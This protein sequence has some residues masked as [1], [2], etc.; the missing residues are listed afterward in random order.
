M[1]KFLRPGTLDIDSESSTAADEWDMWSSNFDAFFAAIDPALT[2]NKL[3]LLRAHV[4]CHIFKLIKH[5]SSYDEAVKILKARFIKPKSEVYARHCLAT[6]KQQAGE[7]LDQFLD[8]LK[9]L[10][11]DCGFQA[12]SA[13]KVE[14]LAIRDAFITGMSSNAIRQRL[15]ENLELDLNT[16]VKQ[17]RALEMAQRHSEAYRSDSSLAAAPEATAA[18]KPGDKSNGQTEDPPLNAAVPGS[19]STSTAKKCFFFL[20]WP[21]S[22]QESL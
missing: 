5:V 12:A 15:L 8:K 17:A 19:Q 6:Q 10:A 1:D 9:S 11:Q 22:L 13:E 4:L 3:A 20:W 7:T 16:A 2:P 14:E 21:S 18:V